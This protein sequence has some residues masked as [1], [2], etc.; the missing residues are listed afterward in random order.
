MFVVVVFA[1]SGLIMKTDT[2]VRTIYEREEHKTDHSPRFIP[3]PYKIK[4]ANLNQESGEQIIQESDSLMM[5]A[6]EDAIKAIQDSMSGVPGKVV[7]GVITIGSTVYYIDN[8]RQA[9]VLRGIVKLDNQM[10]D[11]ESAGLIGVEDRERTVLTL[12]ES[13]HLS[14]R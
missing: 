14:T 2:I 7:C 3:C 11:L 8:E 6:T 1:D 9:K 4:P 10:K 5:S 13:L 12:I